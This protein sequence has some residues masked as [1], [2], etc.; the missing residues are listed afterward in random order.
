MKFW[1]KWN[2]TEGGYEWL[3][4]SQILALCSAIIIIVGCAVL[5]AMWTK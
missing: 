5:G 1:N 4:L 2:R 3:D